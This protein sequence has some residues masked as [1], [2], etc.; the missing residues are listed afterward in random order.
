MGSVALRVRPTAI[1]AGLRAAVEPLVQVGTKVG[2]NP[3]LASCRSRLRDA[4]S[5]V[6]RERSALNSARNASSQAR[7]TR[8]AALRS[9]EEDVVRTRK[10]CSSM[11]STAKVPVMESK[12]YPTKT[13]I[14]DVE[15][16][17]T[18]TLQPTGGK[19]LK[20]SGTIR[21]RVLSVRHAAHPALGVRAM[22]AAPPTEAELRERVYSDLAEHVGKL[23]AKGIRRSARSL[24][25]EVEQ[26]RDGACMAH[27]EK[28]LRL[29]RASPALFETL[30][31]NE[32]GLIESQRF[33]D[34]TAAKECL[35]LPVRLH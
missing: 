29:L 16:K 3:E 4:E 10:R 31:K 26:A 23:V 24:R 8:V 33:D 15:L 13:Q 20:A 27:A 35:G 1:D 5:K 17:V 34:L 2:P 11:P 9:A 14:L 6:Q 21:P 19:P 22:N 30:R 18:L 28:A 32:K 7:A 25:A 12:S